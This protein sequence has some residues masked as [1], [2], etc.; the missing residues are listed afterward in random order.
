MNKLKSKFALIA[1]MLISALAPAAHAIPLLSFAPSSTTATVGDRLF[2]DVIASDVLDLYAFQFDVA[3]DPVVLGAQGI[4]EGGLLSAVDATFFVPGSIDNT[5][6]R[7]VLTANTL[8]GPI[9]GANGSGVLATLSFQ[10][11][12]AGISNLVLDNVL[13]LDSALNDIAVD[14]VAARISAMPAAGVPEP[15]TFALLLLGA[16]LLPACRAMRR[17][18][19]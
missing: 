10:V 4:T 3:F 11:L 9:S 8:L 12:A 7:L 18:A 14:T 15:A 1:V 19:A 17:D 13:A 16:L 2:I 5:A 6:G